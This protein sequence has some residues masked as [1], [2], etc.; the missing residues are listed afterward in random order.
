MLVRARPATDNF[1]PSTAGSHRATYKI[2]RWLSLQV[3]LHTSRPSDLFAR[4]KPMRHRN[5]PC[6]VGRADDTGEG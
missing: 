3:G 5:A 4:V 2:G 1:R 6:A